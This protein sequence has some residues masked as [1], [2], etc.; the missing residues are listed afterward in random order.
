MNR[1]ILRVIVLFLSIN[2]LSAQSPSM[3]ISSAESC[4]GREVLLNV[5]AKNLANVTAITLKIHY[6]SDQLFFHGLENIS[7]QLDGSVINITDNPPLIS[8]AWTNIIPENFPQTKLFDLR[9]TVGEIPGI[10]TF[11]P[12]C[13]I[14]DANLQII[15]VNYLNGEIVDGIPVITE[16]PVAQSCE[17][18]HDVSFSVKSDRLVVYQWE[19]SS[20][21]G[22]TWS[23]LQNS[24]FI[25]GTNS[26]KVELFNVN[27]SQNKNLYR[28][29]LDHNGCL[30]Y[31]VPAALKVDAASGQQDSD[32]EQS[33]KTWYLANEK[34]AV[35]KFR[36]AQ[37][38]NV[39]IS[40]FS[41]LGERIENL[42]Y[43][44]LNPGSYM[45]SVSL[46]SCPA[47]IYFCRI[48]YPEKVSQRME[49]KK[50]LKLN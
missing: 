35:I 19:V 50:I 39:E 14:A 40:L 37:K 20:D 16:Q 21:S 22:S 45:E 4:A 38:G 1:F 30:S 48:I 24:A 27:K 33:L 10:V 12:G 36:L 42:K 13:E 47:G 17:V 31:S 23:A 28:C 26:E 41:V 34:K 5:T 29:V 6:A 9:F 2:S 25:T 8:V 46:A 7:E 3:V 32:E 11:D 43:D 15:Q 44:D 49:T 18:G